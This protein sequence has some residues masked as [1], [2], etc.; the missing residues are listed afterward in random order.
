ML[1]I[2]LDE[3]LVLAQAQGVDAAGNDV[4]AHARLAVTGTVASVP[5]W[6]SPRRGAI[7]ALL[8]TASASCGKAPARPRRY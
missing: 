1:A 6:C 3:G 8:V 4:L 5:Q 7:M 2:H